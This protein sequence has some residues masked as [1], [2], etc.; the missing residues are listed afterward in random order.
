MSNTIA[1][2]NVCVITG[3]GYLSVKQHRTS[4]PFFIIY[5]DLNVPNFRPRC[6]FCA[7]C[8]IRSI[9][10]FCID[11]RISYVLFCYTCWLVDA[12]FRLMELRVNSLWPS[13]AIWRQRSGS[14]LAQVMACC[15]A[16][17]SH[18]LNQWWLIISRVQSHSYEGSFIRDT[19]AI[20]HYNQLEN[21]S[22][23]IYFEPPRGQWADVFWS[24]P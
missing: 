24:W 16:A 5:G 18:Y 10:R 23:Q 6:R 22:S 3:V 20:D 17:P 21:Y 1:C 14:T 11:W 2:V 9:N 4:R 19:S 15:L 8:L 12:V 7:M 13:D